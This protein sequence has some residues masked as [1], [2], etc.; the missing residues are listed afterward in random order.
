MQLQTQVQIPNSTNPINHSEKLMLLGSCF[1]ENIGE[2]LTDN[3]F[4]VDVNPFGILYNPLSVKAALNDLI[5]KKKFT[6]ADIFLHE[7]IF[8]SFA[9]HSRF[10]DEN[11]NACLEQINKRI[12]ESSQWLKQADR[13]IVTFGSAFV[14]F[15]KES[16][17]VVS[18]CHKMHE[19]TF[20]RKRIEIDLIVSEWI[21]LIKKLLVENPKLKIIFTVSPIRHWKDGAHENQLSK[22]TLLLAIDQLVKKSDCC[23]YFPAYEIVMDELR[24]YRFYAEDMIH[25]SGLAID[26]IWNRFTQTRLSKQCQQLITE[27]Q[28]VHKAIIHRPFNPK[29]ETYKTFLTQNLTKLEQLTEKYPYF[30]LSS[31]MDQIRE[32]LHS[33]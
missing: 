14:Y 12:I 15:H 21:D 17:A 31:E 16:G 1:A 24:D 10:S 13:L 3:K 2:K 29:S 4:Q 30:A 7:G 5:D 22:A 9:H 8:H 11:P 27:W 20:Y 32:Q 33:F 26:Y 28:I 19:K 25:P 6:E 18:N 23:S